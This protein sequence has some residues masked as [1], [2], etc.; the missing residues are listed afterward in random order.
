VIAEA[1][2]VTGTVGV[3]KTSVAYAIGEL[4]TAAEVPHAVID[5]DALCQAWPS[6]PGDPFN[7]AMELRNLRSVATNY[8]AAGTERLVLAGVV[9]NVDD[10]ERYREAVGVPLTVARLRA[11]LD[12]VGRRLHGRHRDDESGLRWHLHRSGELDAIL[13]AAGVAD[14][15]VRTDDRTVSEVAADVAK[16]TGWR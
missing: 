6:P 11:D 5:L 15:E 7:F 16:R 14:F 1:L 9:E 2:L 4:L 3:G 13:D 10:R 12:E 8:L